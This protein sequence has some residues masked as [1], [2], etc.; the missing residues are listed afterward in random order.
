MV[1]MK[2]KESAMD[3][4]MFLRRF[5]LVAAALAVGPAV[6]AAKAITPPKKDAE[7]PIIIQLTTPVRLNTIANLRDQ[8][9]EL[10]PK[11]KVVILPHNLR[12]VHGRL[13]AFSTDGKSFFVYR[14]TPA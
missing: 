1:P 9:H 8:W 11:N 6:A 14:P 7:G 10:F 5:G 12:Y 3:R 2:N 13:D 4:R